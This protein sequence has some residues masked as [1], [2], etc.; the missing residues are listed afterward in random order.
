MIQYFIEIGA[1][2][3]M[4]DV[5]ALYYMRKTGIRYKN[6]SLAT[7]KHAQKKGKNI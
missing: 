3:E 5:G 1:Y 4:T 6:K 7:Q 2:F